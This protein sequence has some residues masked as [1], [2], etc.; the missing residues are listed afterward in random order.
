MQLKDF[1][2][3]DHLSADSYLVCANTEVK[4]GKPITVTAPMFELKVIPLKDLDDA[5][6]YQIREEGTYKV[7]DFHASLANIEF[8]FQ[9]DHALYIVREFGIC[10]SLTN[11]LSDNQNK[12]ETM[13]EDTAKQCMSEI[14]V[15]LEYLSACDIRYNLDP[16]NVKIT[17]NGHIKL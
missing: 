17:E 5:L 2:I 7:P 15:G 16:S 10:G 11:L 1:R 3:C 6:R 12:V 14:I 9:N 4:K 8:M 13:E